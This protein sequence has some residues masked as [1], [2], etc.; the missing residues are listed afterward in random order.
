MTRQ[1]KNYMKGGTDRQ[2]YGHCDYWTKAAQGP[3][4]WK[5]CRITVHSN[6][7]LLQGDF[8]VY[9]CPCNRLDWTNG[10]KLVSAS[11]LLTTYHRTRFPTVQNNLLITSLSVYYICLY[12]TLLLRTTSCIQ[13]VMKCRRLSMTHCFSP[14]IVLLLQKWEIIQKPTGRKK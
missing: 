11:L 9:L 14:K 13:K 8:M 2:T 6:L 4:R 10:Q 7:F 12:A 5:F 3:I 1:F